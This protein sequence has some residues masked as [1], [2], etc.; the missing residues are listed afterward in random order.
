LKNE[1]LSALAILAALDNFVEHSCRLIRRA[2][3]D[4]IF[5]L[6]LAN[7]TKTRD[8]SLRSIR[9]RTKPPWRT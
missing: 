6:R 4:R 7:Q 3:R 5:R 8:V 2:A 1:T 9:Y